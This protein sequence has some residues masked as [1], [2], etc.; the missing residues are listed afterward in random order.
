[1]LYFAVLAHDNEEFLRFQVENIRYFNPGAQIVLYNSSGDE[2]F[3]SKAG[4][5]IC[6]YSRR[7]YYGGVER[8]L[9]DIMRWL[10]ETHAVYDYLVYLDSDVLFI[11]HGFEDHLNSLMEGYDFIGHHYEIFSPIETANK[12]I[13][14]QDMVN[15]WA[16]WQPFF[17]TDYFCGTFNPGQTYRKSIV[18]RILGNFDSAA[19]EKMF[20]TIPGVSLEEIIFPTLVTKYGGKG[21]GFL[22]DQVTYLRNEVRLT[23]KEVK[24]ARSL[25]DVHLLHPVVRDLQ[26]PSVAWVRLWST[27]LTVSKLLSQMFAKDNEEFVTSA[28]QQLLNRAPDPKGF[29]THLQLLNTQRVK[30]AVVQ[31]MVRSDEFASLV[32]SDTTGLASANLQNDVRATAVERLQA[33][34]QTDDREC[35]GGWYQEILNRRPDESGLQTHLDMLA[36]GCSKRDVAASILLSGEALAQFDV[37]SSGG[38]NSSVSEAA[39]FTASETAA[40]PPQT[41]P[42]VMKILQELWRYDGDA[43]IKQLYLAVFGVRPGRKAVRRYQRLY[44]K[45]CNARGGSCR[46]EKQQLTFDLLTRL[47]T[48]TGSPKHRVKARGG[49]LTRALVGITRL[50]GDAFVVQTYRQVLGRE[51][52]SEGLSVHRRMLAGGVDKWVILKG[53]LQSQEVQGWL[54]GL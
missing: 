45:H 2:S 38:Q 39:E 29:A 18:Q 48:V 50:D 33:W 35:I 40:A 22:P 13:P 25:P 23:A 27:D 49:R 28:Y 53:I 9:Y 10:E 14:G 43:F 32:A 24:T 7:L 4:V 19:L 52:D 44:F 20:E 12:W 26:H 47:E 34:S 46:L 51:P 41:A 5:E 8:C 37:V 21:R 3:G 36:S 17:D 6:P 1:M 42:D 11:R 31:S 30:S 15:R 54:H 16:L